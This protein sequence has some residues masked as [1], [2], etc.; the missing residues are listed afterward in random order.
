MLSKVISKGPFILFL[1]LSFAFI[2]TTWDLVNNP[3]LLHYI[4]FFLSL[5]AS[6]SATLFL[7]VINKEKNLNKDRT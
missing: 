1:Y 5:G 7:M 3:D 4:Y 6:I 2:R